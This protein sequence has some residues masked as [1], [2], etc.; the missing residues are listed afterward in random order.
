[1]ASLATGHECMSV[2]EHNNNL[3]SLVTPLVPHDVLRCASGRYGLFAD[4]S[5][6]AS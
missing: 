6:T 1:M 3:S 5:P 2:E 4:P